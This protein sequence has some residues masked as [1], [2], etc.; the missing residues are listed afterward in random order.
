M[1]N[2]LLNLAAEVLAAKMGWLGLGVI[3]MASVGISEQEPLK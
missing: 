3:V 2:T 1:L